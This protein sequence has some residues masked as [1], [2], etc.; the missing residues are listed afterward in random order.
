MVATTYLTLQS[1][2]NDR[3]KCK[4]MVYLFSDSDTNVPN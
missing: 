2:S 3:L 4:T 1:Q